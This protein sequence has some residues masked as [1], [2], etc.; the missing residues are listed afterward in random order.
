MSRRA[1]FGD[2]EDESED[3][4]EPAGRFRVYLGAVAGVGK[5]WAMLDEGWRRYK[6]GADVVVG[7][8]E[9]HGREHTAQQIR[10]LPVVPRKACQYRGTNFEEM[11]LEAV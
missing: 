9:T 3:S 2:T 4:V 7:F 5:T 10:D 1:E 6:R 8:V 11:D